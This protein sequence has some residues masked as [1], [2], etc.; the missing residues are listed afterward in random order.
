MS[1]AKNLNKKHATKQIDRFLSNKKF[2]IWEQGCVWVPYIIRQRT[3]ILIS[4]DWTEFADDDQSM[5]ALNLITT[6]GRATPLLWKTANKTS[7]KNNR[8]RYEYQILFQLKNV[9]P[10]SIKVTTIADRGFADQKFLESLEKELGFYYIITNCNP[11]STRSYV[12][13]R[14]V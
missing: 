13:E 5:I 9:L 3:E 10:D 11:I 1:L 6:Q 8:A 7:L 12:K 14:R 2:D 4:M